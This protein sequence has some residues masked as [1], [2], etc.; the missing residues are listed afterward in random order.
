MSK[1]W[2][3]AA[4]RV[5]ARLFEYDPRQR[6]VSEIEDFLNPEGR[7]PSGSRGE[8]RP[9]R[10]F[11]S[12][13]PSRHAIE[14]HTEPATKAAARFAHVL[15]SALEDGRVQHRFDAL[16]LVASPRFLGHLRQS[17]PP[18]LRE[19]VTREVHR[20]MTRATLETIHEMVTEPFPGQS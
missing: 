6:R 17:M 1:T 18:S 12:T 14:P 16:V 19:C 10:T 4:D 15:A 20:D 9:P 11:D 13:G 2:I 7:A 5:R 3:V 8:N